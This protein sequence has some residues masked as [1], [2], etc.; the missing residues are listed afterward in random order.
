MSSYAWSAVGP[1]AYPGWLI[2][3]TVASH[4]MICGCLYCK[5]A[6]KRLQELTF[7]GN[8]SGKHGIKHRPSSLPWCNWSNHC[9][10]ALNGHHLANMM[11]SCTT[12]AGSSLS[13]SWARLQMAA[14]TASLG[15]GG[16]QAHQKVLMQID[17]T[18]GCPSS[19]RGHAGSKQATPQRARHCELI[20]EQPCM[21]HWQWV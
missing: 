11:W 4:A 21:D 17:S 6:E 2:M 7:F 19:R 18:Q 16:C 12:T 10:W 13:S 9:S 1:V 3:V 14:P 8:S 5:T 15:G 20:P